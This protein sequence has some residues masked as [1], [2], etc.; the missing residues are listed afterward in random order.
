MESTNRMDRLR[1]SRDAYYEDAIQRGL[2]A[3]RE[4]ALEVLEYSH[5]RVIAGWD[6]GGLSHIETLKALPIIGV[7]GLEI[8]DIEGDDVSLED[9][10]LHESYPYVQAFIRG[11]C[12]VASEFEAT[13]PARRVEADWALRIRE[14]ASEWRDSGVATVS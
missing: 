9:R 12:Q 11:I 4:C 2:T 7:D 10:A 3:G 14:M 1:V 6:S 13:L 8:E 5:L